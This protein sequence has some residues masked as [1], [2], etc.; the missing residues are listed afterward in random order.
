MLLDRGI[1]T[2]AE[3]TAIDQEFLALLNSEY[4]ASKDY[5]MN[6]ADWIPKEWKGACL[7]RSLFS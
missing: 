3:V 4:Q 6:A 7:F 1:A 2:E 5:H